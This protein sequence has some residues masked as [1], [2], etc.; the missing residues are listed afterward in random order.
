MAKDKIRVLHVKPTKEID[1]IESDV[2]DDKVIVQKGDKEPQFSN[3]CVYN[4]K[5]ISK[6]RLIGRLANRLRKR[7]SALIYVD[8]KS[9]CEK[10]KSEGDF[11]EPITDKD[12]KDVVRKEILK[13]LGKYQIMKPWM[14]IGL[15][16]PI[17]IVIILQIILM[18]GG[19]P[20]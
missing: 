14:F 6:T 2:E 12:R 13:T 1:V 10:P 11:T 7:E 4:I 16:I 17:I 3:E 9:F 18:R 8:G 20:F 15:L 5:F 19:R